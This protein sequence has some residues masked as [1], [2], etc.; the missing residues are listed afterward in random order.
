VCNLNPKHKHQTL[1]A[2]KL[3]TGRWTLPV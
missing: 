3:H 2:V 1:D